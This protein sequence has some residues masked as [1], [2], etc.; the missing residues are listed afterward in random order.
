MA[1]SVA[2]HPSS[3]RL[4]LVSA[5]EDC[6]VRVWSLSSSECLAVLRDHMS[7]PT[8]IAFMPDGHTMITAGRDQV[9]NIW[10]V[11]T[12]RMRRTVPVYEALEGIVALPESFHSQ[13]KSVS[14]SAQLFAVAGQKGVVRIFQ[15]TEVEGDEKSVSCKCIQERPCP[16]SQSAFTSLLWR[17]LGDEGETRGE[18]VAITEDHNFV[19]LDEKLDVR[20]LI[21]GFNDEIIDIKSI[22]GSSNI[23][24]ATNSPEL[25]IFDVGTFAVKLLNGHTDVVL[26]V[27]VSPDG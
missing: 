12:L 11:R 15:L 25:R 10:D 6:T 27:D 26:A 21:V 13:Q 2:F 22:P 9:L 3:K 7:V 17:P 16:D 8:G 19:F 4:L 20:K 24:V 1:T 18:L 5:S 14:K 23:A